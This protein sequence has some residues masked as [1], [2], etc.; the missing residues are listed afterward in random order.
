[1]VELSSAINWKVA[2]GSSVI[3][4]PIYL[5][6]SVQSYND[7]TIGDVKAALKGALASNESADLVAYLSWVIRTLTLVAD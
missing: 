3:S 1:V 2:D 4:N 6:F 5:K 7:L